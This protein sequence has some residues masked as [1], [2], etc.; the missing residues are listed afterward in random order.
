MDKQELLRFL[1]SKDAI[2]VHCSRSNRA[3]EL[4]P[5][6]LYP[7]DLRETISDLCRASGR[8]VSCSVVWP[9]HQETFGEVGIIVRPRDVGEI[10]RLSV[11]D[12]GTLEDG[13]GAGCPLSEETV[14]EIFLAP[15]GHNEWVLTGG[16]VVGI[17]LNFT[18][19]LYVARLLDAPPGMDAG[20]AA[21]LGFKPEPYPHKISIPEIAADFPGL[22]LFGFIEGRLVELDPIDG[23]LSARHPYT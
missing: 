18:M 12:G 5:K 13:Q 23:E 10:V 4:T 9:S 15:K 2:I 11:C 17:F 14:A 6:P 22:P 3:G 7:A 20:E 8:S 1:E 16:E 21:A 19:G